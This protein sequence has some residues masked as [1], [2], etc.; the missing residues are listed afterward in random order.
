[1]LTAQKLGRKSADKSALADLGFEEEEGDEDSDDYAARYQTVSEDAGQ[2]LD[3][4]Q[5]LL[6]YNSE[7]DPKY[8]IVLKYLMEGIPETGAWKDRGCIIFS[9]Y[10]D[11]VEWLAL[12]LSGDLPGTP[13]GIY[14]GGNK[15]ALVTDGEIIRTDR[16][17]IK[18]SVQAGTLKILIGTDAASEGL[19]LQRLGTLINL[20]LPWNPTRLE[21][22]KGRIQ[23]IG[24]RNPKIY[25]LNLRYKDSVE[26]KVHASLSER[27]ESIYD[28]FG[29]IP[30][31][32]QDV[33]V[34]VAVGK[35]EDAEKRIGQIPVKH[36]FELRY[37]ADTTPPGPK[38]ESCA[39]VVGRAERMR[40][41]KQAW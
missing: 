32:L 5:R 18:K 9:A 38:W 27:L 7:P 8:A 26:D 37:K 40:A 28:L 13:I 19:N 36:P 25:L 4:I 24:Q 15:S 35:I 41:L 6:A 12:K 21:Q 17:T 23:R 30:D 16:D 20:D 31:T 33:W 22:R 29:Q 1:M 10:Y 2:I 39:D 14:A 11:S 3:K 34:D